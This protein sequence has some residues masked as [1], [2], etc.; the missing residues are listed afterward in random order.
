MAK[1]KL[2]LS[3]NVNVEISRNQTAIF[4]MIIMNTAL[5]IAYFVEV[6]KGVHTI[7]KQAEQLQQ[8]VQAVEN[9]NKQV[10]ENIGNVSAVTEE[11]TASANETLSN[12]NRNLESIEKVT[13]IMDTLGQDAQKLHQAEAI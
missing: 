6:L 1:T 2:D 8:V 13:E 10:V 12:C 11:V 4:G 5:T 7:S 9:A 3:N